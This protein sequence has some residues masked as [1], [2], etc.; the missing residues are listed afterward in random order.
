MTGRSGDSTG[1]N[2]LSYFV[3]LS[4]DPAT[5]YTILWDAGDGAVTAED[6]AGATGDP[7]LAARV[8]GPVD[9][10]AVDRSQTFYDVADPTIAR[11][12]KRIVER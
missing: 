3:S 9:P 2:A 4:V 5:W 11:V 12:T 10:P 8:Y 7:Y 6:F 1:A